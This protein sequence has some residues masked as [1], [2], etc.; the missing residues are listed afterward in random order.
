MKAWALPGSA[1][2]LILA[3]LPAQGFAQ[4]Q[5]EPQVPKLDR[6]VIRVFLDKIE[7]AGRIEKPQAIFI[8]PGKSPEIEDIRIDRTFFREIFRKV[9]Y[10]TGAR[11]KKQEV[12]RKEYILW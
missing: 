8:I 4:Q 1:L 3:L 2:A 9:E 12:V 7:V 10:P 6:K 5:T 11:R